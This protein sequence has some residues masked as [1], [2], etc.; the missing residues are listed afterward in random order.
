MISPTHEPNHTRGATPPETHPAGQNQP[1]PRRGLG[2][3][4]RYIGR[5]AL[6]LSL[7]GAGFGHLT[8]QRQEFQAQVPPWIPLDPDFVVVASGVVELLLGAALVLVPLRF[9]PALGWIVAAFFVAVF[10]GNIS[11]YV[12]QTDGFG[13]DTDQARFTR[14]FFQPVLVL[15]ALWSTS[16]WRDRRRVW[17]QVRGRR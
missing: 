13:L 8:H 2:E 6:G 7:L 12:T 11:Q 3:V 14:L 15:W 5:I 10:P 1:P 16:A 17:A 9:R 4:V